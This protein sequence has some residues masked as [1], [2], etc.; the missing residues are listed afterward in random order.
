MTTEEI[1]T[2]V[3]RSGRIRVP[4]FADEPAH[5][6]ISKLADK[7][8]DC[9]YMRAELE[10]AWRACARV[11]RL[12]EEKIPAEWKGTAPE[13]E[14]SLRVLDPSVWGALMD[15]RQLRTEIEREIHRLTKD[16]ATVS[17]VYTFLTGT[18]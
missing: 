4:R 12:F 6:R 9:A 5:V 10:E 8:L 17:R 15:A 16:E 3:E 2:V 13:R 14:R 18:S 11:C 7:M 1:R